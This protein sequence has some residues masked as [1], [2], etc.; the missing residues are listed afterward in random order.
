LDVFGVAGRILA[1]PGHTAGSISVLLDEGD[2][3][4]GD[5]LMGGFL[6]GYVQERTPGLTYFIDDLEQ[7]LASIRTV[8]ELPITTV[9]VGHGGPLDPVQIRR[10]FAGIPSSAGR[11][12]GP[13]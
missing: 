13:K 12:I 10:W 11:S 4:A 3:L 7:N 1:T 2:L 8:L 5:L 6:G 9:F